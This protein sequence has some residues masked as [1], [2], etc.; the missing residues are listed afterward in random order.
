MRVSDKKDTEEETEEVLNS[1]TLY[2]P[3]ATWDRLEQL[4][5]RSRSESVTEAVIKALKLYDFLL[6]KQEDGWQVRIAKDGDHKVIAL[7]NKAI[8]KVLN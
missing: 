3:P 8:P 4:V 1:I 7:K 5:Q 6:D 2:A